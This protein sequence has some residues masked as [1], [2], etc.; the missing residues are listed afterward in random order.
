M[1]SSFE[2]LGDRLDRLSKRIEVNLEQGVKLVGNV[3]LGE[4]VF[5]TP[6]DTGRARSNHIVT[7]NGPST[8]TRDAFAPG[9]KLGSQETANALAAISAGSSVIGRFNI[10][11]SAG[12]FITNNLDYIGLLNSGSSTQAPNGFVDN[13]VT[14]GQAAAKRIKVTR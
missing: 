14:A 13:A 7:L 2:D 10:R 1:A 3:V 11:K 9:E 6:A 12:I 4:L 5:G 8:Q